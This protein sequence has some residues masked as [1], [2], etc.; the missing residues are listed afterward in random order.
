MDFEL[1]L[2]QFSGTVFAGLRKRAEGHIFNAYINGLGS[3]GREGKGF[4]VGCMVGSKLR[5]SFLH[6]LL[7]YLVVYTLLA[8]LFYTYTNKF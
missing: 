5:L 8:I 1:A 4:Q 7:W 6:L 2:L 3:M